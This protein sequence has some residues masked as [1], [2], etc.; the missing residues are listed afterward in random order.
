MVNGKIDNCI[1][2]GPGV[3]N[4]AHAPDEYVPVADLVDAA[5][6]MALSTLDLM[7]AGG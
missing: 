6:I 5:K 7:S 3:L 2:H 1:L 4:L